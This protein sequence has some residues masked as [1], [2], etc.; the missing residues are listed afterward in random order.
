MFPLHSNLNKVLQA[1]FPPNYCSPSLSNFS[2][3]QVV[4]I[5]CNYYHFIS[6]SFLLSPFLWL[7][8]NHVSVYLWPCLSASPSF[9]INL[10][11]RD[12]FYVL[13]N[14]HSVFFL[15]YVLF[16]CG[17]CLLSSCYSVYLWVLSSHYICVFAFTFI[18][19]VSDWLV[20]HCLVQIAW[21]VIYLVRLTHRLTLGWPLFSDSIS[22]GQQS[23]VH[24]KHGNYAIRNLLEGGWGLGSMKHSE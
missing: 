20:T 15:P 3:K 5:L 1:Y 6:H 22:C 24:T 21:L 19:R 9:G 14:S 17:F 10:S 7:H 11:L 12:G 13:L 4:Y 8:L 2:L 23:N 18:K 16:S